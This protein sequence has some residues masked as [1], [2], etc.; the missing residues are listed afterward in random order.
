MRSDR[1][2]GFQKKEAACVRAKFLP[3]IRRREKGALIETIGKEKPGW[4][5]TER[6]TR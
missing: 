2:N 5:R 6:A 1:S 4:G 3:G